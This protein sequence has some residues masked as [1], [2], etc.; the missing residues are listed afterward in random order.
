ML[1]SS[2][3]GSLAF[4]TVCGSCPG[5]QQPCSGFAV[6]SNVF[7]W[8]YQPCVWSVPPMK[9][10]FPLKYS[11]ICLLTSLKVTSLFCFQDC[12]CCLLAFL[13]LFQ[14]KSAHRS[15]MLR[16]SPCSSAHSGRCLSLTGHS[17]GSQQGHGRPLLNSGS[18]L[19]PYL[20]HHLRMFWI[21]S[22]SGFCDNGFTR[23]PCGCSL[24]LSWLLL[25]PQ[26]RSP[27][28]YCNP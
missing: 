19:S 16:A 14:K 8:K 1:R 22:S 27:P 13:L 20:P 15:S 12:L 28:G 11:H 9:W 2:A 18:V 7:F 4:L 25:S 5:D 6:L 10:F 21:S 3:P 26:N 17:N 24:S 23:V